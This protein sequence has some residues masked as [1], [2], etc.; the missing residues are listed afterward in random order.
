MLINA[1][2]QR[3]NPESLPPR[4]KPGSY[5]QNKRDA[6][7]ASLREVPAPFK[8]TGTMFHLGTRAYMRGA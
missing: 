3:V 5:Q 7:L 1:K 2:G 4:G 6:V 8:G